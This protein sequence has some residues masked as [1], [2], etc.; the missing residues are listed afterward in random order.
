[1]GL[2]K[3]TLSIALLIAAN[4]APL[5]G[6]LW[7]GW[8]AGVVILVY[9]TENLVVGF[10]N[11]LR[12][13]TLK[14]EHTFLQLGKLF[15]VPFFCVHFGGFCAIHGA[16]LMALIMEENAWESPRP[17]M[18]LPGPLIFLG[19]LV[20]VV[21]AVWDARPP[22]TG[23]I[24]GCL[25]LSHGVSFVYNHFV[26]GEYTRLTL[27][28]LMSRPY[29]RIALLHIA[30]LAGAVPIMML[31]SP[32]PLLVILVVMKIGLDSVLHAWT[33]RKAAAKTPAGRTPEAGL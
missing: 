8:D 33:H 32:T 9:W 23:W 18:D 24:V 1:M 30:I 3:L 13:L 20:S 27:G 15:S 21:S 17:G 16:I 25:V 10:Y 2:P 28:D 4:L 22:G 5:V 11:I 7:F 26:K 31:G 29:K 19:L 6:V 12:M 14:P